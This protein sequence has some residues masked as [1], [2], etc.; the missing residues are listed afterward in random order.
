MTRAR[1]DG[2][3]CEAKD[4]V[5]REEASQTLPVDVAV[6]VLLDEVA[7]QVRHHLWRRVRCSDAHVLERGLDVVILLE[8]EPEHLRAG[9]RPV[10]DPVPER[11]A[12]DLFEPVI[13]VLVVEL[14]EFDPLHQRGEFE[15]QEE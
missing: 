7:G 9:R 3:G 14:V 4:D 2:S 12:V 15:P 6:R 5:V 8:R 10:H 11:V 1:V 13:A